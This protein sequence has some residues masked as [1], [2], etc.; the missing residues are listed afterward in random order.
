M[1][2][3][4]IFS[5]VHQGHQQL[6][7]SAQFGRLPKATQPLFRDLEHLC[8]GFSLYTCETLETPIL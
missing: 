2:F 1:R 5:P 6:I 8:K 7:G 4:S 3:R